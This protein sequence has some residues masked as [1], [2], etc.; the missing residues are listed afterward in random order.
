MGEEEEEGCDGPVFI[1]NEERVAM[2]PTPSPDLA[3][4]DQGPQ[5]EEPRHKDDAPWTPVRQGADK[6]QH[7]YA[8][9]VGEVQE[10]EEWMRPPME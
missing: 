10:E 8:T 2:S 6:S 9:A 3:Y 1:D 5:H 4:E 7:A